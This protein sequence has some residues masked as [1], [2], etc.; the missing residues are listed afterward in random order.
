M[1]DY[2]AANRYQFDRL[3]A[4]IKL[5][6]EDRLTAGLDGGWSAAVGLAHLAFWDRRAVEILRRWKS[7]KAPPEDPE[8]YGG[9]DLLNESLL[10]LWRALPAQEAVRLSL[11]AA[12]E[13]DREVETTEGGLAA[14][15][16]TAGED[17]LLNRWRHR[18]EHLSEIERALG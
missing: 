13:V 18:A 3:A 16:V 9:A 2:V 10:P 4:L 1:N 5:V 17:W 6:T 7:G 12:S 8:W 11:E 14:V 15:I